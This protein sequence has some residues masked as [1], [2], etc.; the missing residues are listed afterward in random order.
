MI[1]C[2]V[3]INGMVSRAATVRTN[4]EDKHSSALVSRPPFPPSRERASKWKSPCQWMEVNRTPTHMLWV[5]R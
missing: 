5:Q 3:T 4:S 2:N 1:K